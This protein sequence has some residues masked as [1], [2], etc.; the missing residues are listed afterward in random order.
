MC[1]RTLTRHCQA[2]PIVVRQSGRSKPHLTIPF[3]WHEEPKVTMRRYCL[4]LLYTLGKLKWGVF[5][6][7]SKYI[8]TCTRI[9]LKDTWI[10]LDI[11]INLPFCDVGVGVEAQ[12]QSH[13]SMLM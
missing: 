3:P 11:G 7:L 12:T 4:G 10:T 1:S 6:T 8:P 2:K 13:Q 5:R 9:P